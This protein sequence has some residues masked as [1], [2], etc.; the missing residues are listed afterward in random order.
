MTK[1]AAAAKIAVDIIISRISILGVKIYPKLIKRLKTEPLRLS[2]LAR[3]ERPMVPAI[4]NSRI[5][6]IIIPN[7]MA[8][9][10]VFLMSSKRTGVILSI[11]SLGLPSVTSLMTS[12]GIIVA[13]AAIKTIYAVK[14]PNMIKTVIVGYLRKILV[15][16]M[17]TSFITNTTPENFDNLKNHFK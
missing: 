1:G 4:T 10:M 17:K 14:I 3:F 13:I 5:T 2:E 6:S 9:S 8:V 12:G 11:I 16:L 15:P 7:K